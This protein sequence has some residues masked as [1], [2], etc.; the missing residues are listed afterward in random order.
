[1]SWGVKH[2][3]MQINLCHK[4]NIYKATCKQCTHRYP[5]EMGVVFVSSELVYSHPRPGQTR[6]VTVIMIMTNETPPS[7]EAK[8]LHCQ[9]RA[10]C[11]M[12]GMKVIEDEARYMSQAPGYIFH[13]YLYAPS[14]KLVRRNGMMVEKHPRYTARVLKCE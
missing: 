5:S 2:D 8:T 12:P 1:M 6:E 10:T 13:P 4:R 3:L 14:V 7:K 11:R 9:E